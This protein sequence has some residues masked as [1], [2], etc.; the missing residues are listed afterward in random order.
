MRA[1]GL[2]V[3]GR[4]A[5]DEDAAGCD[6]TPSVAPIASRVC[7]NS[8][9]KSSVRRAVDIAINT[10]VPPVADIFEPEPETTFPD[11]KHRENA[12]YE[13][14][15]AKIHHFFTRRARQLEHRR[16][17]LLER[18]ELQKNRRAIQKAVRKR[19][20]RRLHELRVFRVRP[21]LPACR[22]ARAKSATDPT[23]RLPACAAI[24]RPPFPA[25]PSAPIYR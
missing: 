4:F 12:E 5:L 19:I 6:L 24:S 17:D 18:I 16:L 13:Q 10:L 21:A 2:R 20:D 23:S 14:E 8:F 11:V 22:S 15:A 9:S 25:R 1:G 3:R 7:A